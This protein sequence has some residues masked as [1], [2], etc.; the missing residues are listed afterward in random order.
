MTWE[1][2]PVVCA[3]DSGLSM[4]RDQIPSL[5]GLKF[6]AAFSVAFSHAAQHILPP[7]TPSWSIMMHTAYDLAVSASGFGMPLFFVLSGFV[8]HYN[9][10]ARI[11]S[12][13]LYEVLNFFIA[14]FS[15]L[16]PLYLCALFLSISITLKNKE[17][18][19]GVLGYYVLMLQSW[20]FAIYDD[21]SLMLFARGAW[22]DIV[23]GEHRMV[24]LCRISG[25]LFFIGGS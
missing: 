9:Y 7:P 24:F 22:S 6:I 2:I 16:Y 8:I 17:I 11:Q 14:R 10:S 4:R 15:R 1:F 21:N 12:G 19:L 5:T 20:F 13:S 23:V 3:N 18:P 25:D